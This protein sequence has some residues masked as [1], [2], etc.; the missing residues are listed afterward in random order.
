MGVRRLK[1]ILV[2]E[3]PNT[4]ND[5]P[6]MAWDDEDD[7]LGCHL[8]NRQTGLWGSKVGKPIDC[9]LKPMPNK[10]AT[11]LAIGIDLVDGFKDGWNYGW[12]ACLEEIER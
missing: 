8:T 5:C 9:P 3:M 10:Q 1:A 4:C 2:L 7:W 11:N 12:N 6:M